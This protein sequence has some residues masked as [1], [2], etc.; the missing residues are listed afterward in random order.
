MWNA[1]IG[2]YAGDLFQG[3]AHG[4]RAIGRIDHHRD[5]R[6]ANHPAHSIGTGQ[7]PVAQW[8]PLLSESYRL[9]PQHQVRKIDVPF[10]G[11]HVGALGHVT[12]VAQVTL[13]DNFPVVPMLYPIDLHGL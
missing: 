10:V 3:P 1:G 5:T 8:G 12:Q 4:T 2:V 9:G 7:Q 11:R 6:Q 13:I